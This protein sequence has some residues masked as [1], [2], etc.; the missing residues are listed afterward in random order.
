MKYYMLKFV[1][2]G[3]SGINIRSPYVLCVSVIGSTVCSQ[4][5]TPTGASNQIWCSRTGTKTSR[6]ASGIR[7]LWRE[8]GGSLWPGGAGQRSGNYSP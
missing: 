2:S 6:L 7:E 5:S 8:E 4:L 1:F 3:K